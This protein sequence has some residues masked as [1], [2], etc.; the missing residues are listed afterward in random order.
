MDP[1]SKFTNVSGGVAGAVKLDHEGHA[2]GVAVF[3]NES[4]WLTEKEEILTANAPRNEADNPFV[5]GTFRCDVK[6]AD[7][8]HA[9][10]IGSKHANAEPPERPAEAGEGDPEGID[11]RVETQAANEP[12]VQPPAPPAPP[13][14]AAP[15]QPPT[16]PAP[17]P[18]EDPAAA[19]SLAPVEEPKAPVTPAPEPGQSKRDARAAAPAPKA[20]PKPA[21][22][23]PAAPA[24]APTPA[25]APKP[26]PSE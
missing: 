6:S 12:P 14:P 22:P 4:V 19:E 24:P 16:E 20:A 18:V 25:A 9:R 23:A 1:Q 11:L 7:A 13:A 5:N 26:A 15:P 10:P 3:P 8:G 21:T 2:K 17:P